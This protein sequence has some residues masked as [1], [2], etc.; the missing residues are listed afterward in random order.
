MPHRS[1]HHPPRH[2]PRPPPAARVRRA[3]AT[4]GPTAGPTAGSTLVELLVG[5]AIAGVLA[6]VG[7]RAAARAYDSAAVHAAGAELR[8]AFA[9]ARTLAVLRATR[10]A[11]RLDTV[12]GSA[13]VHVGEDTLRRLA[14]T[15]QFGARLVAVTRDSMAYSA[16]GLGYG[17]SNLRVVL[18][19]GHATDTLVV[20]RLGRVR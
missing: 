18:A 6:A 3:P 12:G 13:A 4:A 10:V 16:L 17:A 11:V 2:P 7:L 5:L 8:G 14:L 9:A 15:A 1:L 19:R 20:S